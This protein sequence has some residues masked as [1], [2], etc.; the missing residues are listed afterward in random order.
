MFP[1]G[2]QMG[3]RSGLLLSV[4]PEYLT[5]VYQGWNPP[6]A[7]FISEHDLEIS[8]LMCR[9]QGGRGLVYS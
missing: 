1:E 6:V 7:V 2:A 3:C 4:Y 8:Y 9:L 5:R